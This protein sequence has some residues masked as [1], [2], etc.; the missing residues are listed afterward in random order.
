MGSYNATFFVRTLGEKHGEETSCDAVRTLKLSTSTSSDLNDTVSAVMPSITT[1]PA[2]CWPAQRKIEFYTILERFLPVVLGLPMTHTFCAMHYYLPSLP[3]PTIG[4]DIDPS[5]PAPLFAISLL[6]LLFTFHIRIWVIFHLVQLL[7]HQ[8]LCPRACGAT[9]GSEITPGRLFPNALP[10]GLPLARCSPYT[11][12]C[13]PS[14][15]VAHC[16]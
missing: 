10:L 7:L 14:D 5:S 12:R 13:D 15:L 6:L 11:V 2:L 8:P 16:A 4:P 3:W 1:L 9:A